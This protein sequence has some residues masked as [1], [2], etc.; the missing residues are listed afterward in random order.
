MSDFFDTKRD[1]SK[2][3]DFVLGYYLEPYV[4]KVNTLGKPILVVDCFAGRGEFRD[5]QPGSPL[6]IA[7]TIKKWRDKGVPIQSIFIEAH[8]DNHAYLHG[9]MENCREY[10]DVRL[11]S[12]DDHLSEIAQQARQNTVFLYVDP[13]NVRGLTFERMKAVYDQIHMSSVE[14]L[15]NFN[16]AAFMRWALA[17]LQ[18]HN[19][20]PDE[21]ADEPLDQFEDALGE[22]VELAT[23]DA[24]AGGA[25]WRSIALDPALT[26]PQKLDHLTAKYMDR[27]RSSFTYVARCEIK[28][29]YDH[30]VPKYY[31]IYATRHGDGLELINDAMCKARLEFLGREFR[32]DCLFDLTPE[33]ELSDLGELKRDLLAVMGK[34]GGLSRKDLR[35]KG[36]IDHFGRFECKD[37]NRAISELLK[38]GKLSSSSGKSRINDHE[39]LS[40][41]AS[42]S[43]ARPTPG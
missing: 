17:A 8:P 1:W 33:A 3:K 43:K 13:Y 2:Y 23:L 11:G 24:I 14:V 16:A 42:A 40:L 15:L 26:F 32:K 19:D 10:A 29:K 27:M 4:P 37:Y 18:R 41:A 39:V 38:A 31:L 7:E 5:G 34:E 30:R 22:P 6:I 35:L 9:L 25:Y 20:I 12:F 28:A 21:T 36:L